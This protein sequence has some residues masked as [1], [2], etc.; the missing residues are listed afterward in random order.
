LICPVNLSLFKLRVVDA[1]VGVVGTEGASLAPDLDLDLELDRVLLLLDNN[2][3]DGDVFTDK[4]FFVE[5]SDDD[6]DA[7]VVT[8]GDVGGCDILPISY[9][10]GFVGVS[11][12]IM[13]PSFS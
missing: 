9:A 8:D 13:L 1:D 3:D 2:N 6:D 4:V 5:D 7:I 10:I 12:T 11:L